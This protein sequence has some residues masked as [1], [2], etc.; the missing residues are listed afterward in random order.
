MSTEQQGVSQLW[1]ELVV[2]SDI[3]RFLNTAVKLAKIM[4]IELKA[5]FRRDNTVLK[6]ASLPMVHEVCLWTA[7][8]KLISTSLLL[9]AMRI[10]EKQVRNRLASIAK[11]E[12]VSCSFVSSQ[13][14]DRDEDVDRVVP[15]IHLIGGRGFSSRSEMN[16][17]CAIDSGDSAGHTCLQLATHFSIRTGRPLKVYSLEDGKGPQAKHDRPKSWF[18]G[19]QD[20]SCFVLFMPKGAYAKYR[21]GA[22]SLERTPFPV[23]LV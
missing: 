12:A 1:I 19:V 23:L 14:L 10:Q 8:E 20:K 11:R 15:C 7:Q 5:V 21:G 22:V 18:D 16:P 3:E 17:V 2:R 13:E 6:A 9:K 4:G